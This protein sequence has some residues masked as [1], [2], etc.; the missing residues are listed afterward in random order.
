MLN[1]TRLL[2]ATDFSR[3]SA[4]AFDH[5]LWWAATFRADLDLVHC[6]ASPWEAYD[7]DTFPVVD[8][9]EQR[10]Q[11]EERTKGE[12]SALAE[13]ARLKGLHVV[14][15]IV[16]DPSVSH[17]ILAYAEAKN[18]DLIVIG[19]HGHRG[20]GRL[21]LGSVAEQV[22]RKAHCPVFT[23]HEREAEVVPAP[24][25]ILAPVDLSES[26]RRGAR[27]AFEL[28]RRF[29][30]PLELVH[31]LDPALEPGL[32]MP[33]AYPLMVTPSETLREGAEKALERLAGELLGQCPVGV[34]KPTVTWQVLRGSPPYELADLGKSVP[35]A[36]IVMA[37][38][39]HTGLE[40]LLL[41]STAERVLRLSPCPVVTVG[42][43]NATKRN[44]ELAA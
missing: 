23:V 36:W 3:C 24:R 26:S 41:G 34:A 38:E 44:A 22:V 32:Y 17:G 35:G 43:R 30:V 2:L 20:L 12:L 42:T 13:K 4:Q 21:L 11:I 14:T 5:A 29:E 8:L 31:V 25:Q 6:Q 19:T 39:G 1:P 15:E 33:G 7:L 9:A 40:R 16:R 18:V 37:T 28:A 27:L 10:R